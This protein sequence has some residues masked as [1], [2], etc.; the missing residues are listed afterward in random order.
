MVVDD[1]V[2]WSKCEYLSKGVQAWEIE[3]L[4]GMVGW[5]ERKHSLERVLKFVGE[6]EVNEMDWSTVDYVVVE[7]PPSTNTL[8]QIPGAKT[9]I[10][11]PVYAEVMDI[12]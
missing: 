5:D 11:S 12:D 6:R 9:A 2:G 3:G 1:E 10:H 8:L 4:R 7:S